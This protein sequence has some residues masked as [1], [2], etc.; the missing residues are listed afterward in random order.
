MLHPPWPSSCCPPSH[1]LMERGAKTLVLLFLVLCSCTPARAECTTHSVKAAFSAGG[2]VASYGKRLW[3]SQTVVSIVGFF[4]P[5]SAPA[6]AAALE[7]FITEQIAGAQKALAEA[8]Q[9]LHT[10]V[11]SLLMDT[12]TALLSGDL[13]PSD[14]RLPT[15][16]LKVRSSRR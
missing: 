9:Q 12:V 6:A 15:L 4:F 1:R 7:K 11:E 10:D 2:W 14:V 8:A 5:A 3:D 13:T 16:D